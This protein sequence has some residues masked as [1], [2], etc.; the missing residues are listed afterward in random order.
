KL[1]L[2]NA[3]FWQALDAIAKAAD[4]RISLYERDGKIALL[5][6]PYQVAPVSY[7]GLFRVGIKELHVHH[8]LD[9]DTHYCD[10]K[11]EVAWEP[12]FQPLFLENRPDALTVQDDKGRAIDVPEE[13][14]GPVPVGRPTARTIDVRIPAPQRS[15]NR[16]SLFKGKLA[17]MGPT[18]MVAFT[19]DNL[20]KIE[21]AA[22]ARKETKEG[23]SV[24]LREL[25]SEGGG[26][27][28]VW[29]VG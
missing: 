11:L 18:K 1:D 9:S 15:A 26:G 17:V 16:F 25:R 2:K 10:I 6:G 23:V 28:E 22:E 7:S 27:D 5:E 12:R 29:T 19:F 24:N 3:T 20:S 21:K 4:A 13:G 14:R 8:F